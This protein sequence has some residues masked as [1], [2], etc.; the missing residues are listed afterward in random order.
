MRLPTNGT[1]VKTEIKN[2]EINMNEN[3]ISLSLTD[4]DKRNINL[5][6]TTLAHLLEPLLI[7]L[8]ADDR[9]RLAKMS[10]KSIPFMQK[11]A[12]YV[13]SNP[14]F[15]PAYVD[16]PEFKRDFK[17]FMDLREVLRPVL[18][19]VG[20]LEDTTILS[21]ADAYDV[22]RAYYKSVQQAANMNVPNASTIY[23]DLKPRFELK[24]SKPAPIVPAG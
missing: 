8:D 16:V 10:D 23:E 17:T 1:L 14:E 15:V 13:D 12:Q 4:E 2:K 3:R 9:R 21:G 19:L 22:G 6:I 5:A 24:V 18:Q 11:I 20:N 7:A